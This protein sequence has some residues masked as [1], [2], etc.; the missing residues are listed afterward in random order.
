MCNGA[1]CM[2]KIEHGQT[3]LNRRTAQRNSLRLRAPFGN[4]YLVEPDDILDT[5]RALMALDYYRPVAGT[6]PA[7]SSTTTC[8]PGSNPSSATTASRSTASCARA[9]KP[10]RR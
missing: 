8:S 4:N 6:E 5:K 7:P 2:H 3:D 1:N 10:R 9:A